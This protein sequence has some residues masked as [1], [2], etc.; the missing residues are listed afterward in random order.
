MLRYFFILL[1]LLAVQASAQ[2]RVEIW[3]KNQVNVTLSPRLTLKVADRISYIPN[4]E[5]M[6]VVY[7]EV[8]VS[9]RPNNWLEYGGGY[10]FAK[11]QPVKQKWTSESRSM[12]FI[13]FTKQLTPFKLTF[14]NRFEHRNFSDRITRL[15]YKHAFIFQFPKLIKNGMQFYVSEEAFFSLNDGQL[16]MARF[17]GGLHVFANPHF[18]LT[19]YYGLQQNKLFDNWYPSDIVGMNLRFAI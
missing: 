11:I 19:T 8:F 13:D 16:N 10:R 4:A 3:N 7:G 17:F 2:R 18:R 14:R 15:R 1:V 9:D 6:E 5:K 12:L